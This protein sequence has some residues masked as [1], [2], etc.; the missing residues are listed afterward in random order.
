MA[1]SAHFLIEPLLLVVFFVAVVK[2]IMWKLPIAINK[3][4]AAPSYF[5]MLFTF[6]FFFFVK[7]ISEEMQRDLYRKENCNSMMLAGNFLLQ[8][9]IKRIWWTFK[10]YGQTMQN[11]IISDT[12]DW[13]KKSVKNICRKHVELRLGLVCANIVSSILNS[14]CLHFDQLEW[15]VIFIF[16]PSHWFFIEY[17]H[18]DSFFFS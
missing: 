18:F 6:L 7:L 14:N 8:Q 2:K 12:R 3:V 1:M 9:K 17:L 5:Q 11:K 15:N 10:Y 4:D 16:F 13:K